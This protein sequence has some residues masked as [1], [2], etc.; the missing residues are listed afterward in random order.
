[1][2]DAILEGEAIDEGLQGR[3]RR[4][5]C[6]REVHLPGAHRIEVARATDMGADGSRLIV[7]DEDGGGNAR[8]DRDGALPRQRLERGLEIAVDAGVDHGTW[9][10]LPCEALGHMGAQHGEGE[11]ARGSLLD[12]GGLG[13]VAVDEAIALK[14]RDDAVPRQRCGL[15]VAVGPSRL[16]RLGKGDEKRTLGGR[17]PLRLLAEIGKRGGACALDVAAIG[18]E[19]QVEI[20]DLLLREALLDLYRADHLRQL[21]G[22]AALGPRLQKARHLHGERRAA[23]DDAAMAEC[24]PDGA[25]NGP[26]IDTSVLVEALVLIGHEHGEEA[27][28]DI[29]GSHRKPPEAVLRDEGAEQPAVAV[30]DER[31]IGDAFAKRHGP[32]AAQRLRHRE[33]RHVDGEKHGEQPRIEA[34]RPAAAGLRRHVTAFRR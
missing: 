18:G 14:P 26:R 8:A 11:T 12:A 22:D 10:L 33:A 31:R 34:E 2:D 23:R 16:R 15:R 5:Q 19:R 25:G 7:D 20:E 30:D 29:G 27:R 13:L 6:Q 24:L 17:E 28:V 1:M 9:L 3:A 32:E 21:V 4:A